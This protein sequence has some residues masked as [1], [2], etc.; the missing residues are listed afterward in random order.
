MRKPKIKD[1]NY[2]L[3]APNHKQIQNYKLQT[4]NDIDRESRI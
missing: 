3:Q 4:T 1:Q 2:K